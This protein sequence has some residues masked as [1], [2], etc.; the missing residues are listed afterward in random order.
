MADSAKAAHPTSIIRIVAGVNISTSSISGLEGLHP[1]LS[2]SSYT[3]QL[4]SIPVDEP[5]GVG[6]VALVPLG[7]GGEPLGAGG[8]LEV[9]EENML[10]QAASQVSAMLSKPISLAKLLQLVDD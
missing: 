6:G 4:S 9:L 3:C 5:P 8:G 10:T 7:G 2:H 1:S